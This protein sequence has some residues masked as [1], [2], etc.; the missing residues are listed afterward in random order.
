MDEGWNMAACVTFGYPT[1]RWGVA[2]R[3]PVHHVAHRNR[4]GAPLGLEIPE[5]LWAT[6]PAVRLRSGPE[7]LDGF[8]A[9][10]RTGVRSATVP[11]AGG[12]EVARQGSGAHPGQVVML[13]DDL[14]VGGAHRG[15]SAAG[16]R[17]VPR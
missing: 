14:G 13:A 2:K 11:L 10:L 9:V 16:A 8:A 6:R 17:T 4:W 7:V 3:V 15:C 12:R 5:P 1:G